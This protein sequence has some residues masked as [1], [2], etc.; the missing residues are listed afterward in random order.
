MPMLTCPSCKESGRIP[1]KFVG[2][3]IRCKKCGTSLLVTAQGAEAVP[4]T[5]ARPGAPQPPEPSFSGIAVE[6]LDSSAWTTVSDHSIETSP[7]HPTG[8]ASADGA[9]GPSTGAERHGSAKEYKLLTQ[10]DKWFDGKFDLARLEEALNAYARQGWVVKS[11][12]TPTIAG[13]SGGPREEIVV[14]LE[15]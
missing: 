8:P 7:G 15:R 5:A 3:R 10:K 4:V 12:A 1:D 9:T 2:V 13:F 11:M 14:L 6:G